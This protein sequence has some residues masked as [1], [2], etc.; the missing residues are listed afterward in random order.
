[1][2]NI[3]TTLGF[4]TSFANM[5]KTAWVMIVLVRDVVKQSGRL[6]IFIFADRL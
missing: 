4:S 6:S 3:Q 5:P 2:F 1:M